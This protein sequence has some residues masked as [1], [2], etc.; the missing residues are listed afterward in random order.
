[1]VNNYLLY[2]SVLIASAFKIVLRIMLL[3]KCSSSSGQGLL[4]SGVRLLSGCKTASAKLAGQAGYK[5]LLL[6]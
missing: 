2:L 3:S 1:M 4:S 6:G 5:R